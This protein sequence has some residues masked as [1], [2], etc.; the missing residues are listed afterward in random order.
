MTI[1]DDLKKAIDQL[2]NSL[3]AVTLLSTRLRRELSESAQRAVELEAAADQAVR[4]IK[5]LQPSKNTR[6]K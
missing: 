6:E 2:P 5:R 1:S 3:Q 4:T